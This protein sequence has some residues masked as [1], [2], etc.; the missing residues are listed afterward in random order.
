[1]SIKNPFQQ[2]IKLINIEEIRKPADA[3]DN[4][5]QARENPI[6]FKLDLMAACIMENI[7]AVI[8]LA[9]KSVKQPFQKIADCFFSTVATIDALSNPKAMY[10]MQTCLVSSAKRSSRGVNQRQ[11]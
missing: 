8:K 5:Y 1:M 10:A 11:F 4:D 3:E 9:K 7:K 6:P 2:A